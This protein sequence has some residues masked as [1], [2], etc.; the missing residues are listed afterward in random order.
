MPLAAKVLNRKKCG[1]SSG[2][3]TKDNSMVQAIMMTALL[4]LLSKSMKLTNVLI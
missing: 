2:G 1:K 3:A 4:I